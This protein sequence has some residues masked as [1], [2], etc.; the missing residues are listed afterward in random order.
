MANQRL[1]ECGEFSN[2]MTEYLEG[3][4]PKRSA[5]AMSIHEADCED[6]RLS[7]SRLQI[8][9]DA[10]STLR[11]SRR[12]GKKIEYHLRVLR[13][14]IR[15]VGEESAELQ[16]KSGILAFLRGDELD[17]AVNNVPV[18]E[19]GFLAS[20]IFSEAGRLGVINP[21]LALRVAET[22]V[23][24]AEAASNSDATSQEHGGDLRAESLAV[25]G[26]ARRICS[27][28]RGAKRAFAESIRLLDCGTGDPALYAHVLRLRA[29]LL[30]E[31]GELADA[32]IS[33]NQAIDLHKSLGDR[34]LEGRALITRGTVLGPFQEPISAIRD[35]RRGLELIDES[36]EPRIALVARHNLVHSLLE[37][38]SMAEVD[39]IDAP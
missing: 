3:A 16:E 9:I 15:T 12:D 4:L 6:C 13:Q 37:M 18:V 26:N 27:D 38:G 7:L 28:F 17:R 33:I 21:K 8:T 11:R 23:T 32:N 30:S 10:I 20:H 22:G 31:C 39:R 14:P 5:E 1:I 24:V 29:V 19:L 2:R 35:L 36:R 34:H 25:L